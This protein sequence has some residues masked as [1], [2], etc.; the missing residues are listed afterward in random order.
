MIRRNDEDDNAAVREGPVREITDLVVAASGGD[1]VGVRRL[2]SA[3]AVSVDAR[4]HFGNTALIYA[5]AAVRTGEVR[6]LLAAG[7][8]PA[9]INSLGAT[10]L[11]RAEARGHGA[12]AT[13]LA[14][15]QGVAGRVARLALGFAVTAAEDL[16][17]LKA[18][19]EGRVSRAEAALAAGAHV[20][21][22]TPDGGRTPLINAAVG[23][24]AALAALLLDWGADPDARCLAGRTALSYATSLDDS[25]IMHLL[26]HR[27]ADPDA[28]GPGGRTPL[29][30]AAADGN[31]RAVI[32][33]LARGADPRLADEFG[34][35]AA[36]VA[37]GQAAAAMGKSAGPG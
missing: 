9:L 8:D 20:E 25:E 11:E 30:E 2:L 15:A 10:A 34:R 31:A 17:L 3:G 22:R 35:T 18:S 28:R 19:R 4:D 21:A 1:Y 14:R 36:D 16:D 37:T 7:A 6:L 13:E 32:L 29:M 24:H 33:L 5:A 27:G 23:G 12:A 26:L